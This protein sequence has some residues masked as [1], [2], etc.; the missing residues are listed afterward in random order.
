M[1]KKYIFTKDNSSIAE[2]FFYIHC[3]GFGSQYCG[4]RIHHCDSDIH[5]CN[6]SVY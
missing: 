2:A 4:F 5:Y 1:Y 3:C 6:Y